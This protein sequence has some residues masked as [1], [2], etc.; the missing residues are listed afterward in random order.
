MPTG[1]VPAAVPS[2]SFEGGSGN[3]GSISDHSSSDAI[4]G[5]D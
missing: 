1:P 5:C 2:T 3:N 4:H